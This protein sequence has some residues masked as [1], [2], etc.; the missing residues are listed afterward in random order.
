MKVRRFLFHPE[1]DIFIEIL[2]GMSIDL[3]DETN[4]E[5]LL[6]VVPGLRE[7]LDEGI[8]VVRGKI[9]ETGI[10]PYAVSGRFGVPALY[11]GMATHKGG[12]DFLES[13]QTGL[14]TAWLPEQKTFAVWFN[15]EQWITFEDWTEE[16]F[17]EKFDALVVLPEDAEE[18]P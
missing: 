10:K 15:K 3:P 16:Q 17:R 11:K 1:E 9:E 7:F 8:V 14:I 13:E 12:L 5:A 18:S 2:L 6:E 4:E